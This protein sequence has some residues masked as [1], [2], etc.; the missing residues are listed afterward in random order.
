MSLRRSNQDAENVEAKTDGFDMDMSSGLRDLLTI[1]VDSPMFRKANTN[2]AKTHNRDQ[3]R[4]GSVLNYMK[5]SSGSP[6]ITAVDGKKYDLDSI[7]YL[8]DSYKKLSA[9]SFKFAISLNVKLDGMIRMLNVMLKVTVST[10]GTITAEV[11]PTESL[12]KQF[13]LNAAAQKWLEGKPA[14]KP[15]FTKTDAKKLYAAVVSALVSYYK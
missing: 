1:P 2:R 10:S 14:P 15:A 9:T 12:L 7:V 13:K 3:A 5:S 4:R 8:K 11:M 6:Q